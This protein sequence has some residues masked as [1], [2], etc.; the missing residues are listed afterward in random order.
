MTVLNVIITETI[1]KGAAEEEE[2]EDLT[3]GC[4]TRGFSA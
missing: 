2:A 4:K 1:K 3:G